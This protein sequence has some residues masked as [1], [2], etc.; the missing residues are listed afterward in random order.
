M[1]VI[2]MGNV[3]DRT[4]RN[5]ALCVS[6]HETYRQDCNAILEYVIQQG[7]S[8]VYT[9]ELNYTRELM[10]PTQE[11]TQDLN[12]KC[13]LVNTTASTVQ[14]DSLYADVVSRNN[15]T[16]NG[17]VRDVFFC[18]CEESEKKDH[19]ESIWH[20]LMNKEELSDQ[21]YSL[22][23]SVMT[24]LLQ[25]HEIPSC[26]V[27]IQ[28]GSNDEMNNIINAYQGFLRYTVLHMPCVN[29]LDNISWKIGYYLCGGR[30]QNYKY[31]SADILTDC[32]V[33]HGNC[34][35]LH[36]DIYSTSSEMS[37]II[38]QALIN[39][40]E[41]SINPELY[42]EYLKMYD[43]SEMFMAVIY[44]LGLM[45]IIIVFLVPLYIQHTPAA[46]TH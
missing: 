41:S 9:Q 30:C 29:M 17:N 10:N 13:Q 15:L 18:A 7:G 38:T 44:G 1:H 26:K 42:K 12:D 34:M 14:I 11:D 5:I 32:T 3:P 37:N 6:K 46:L 39:E 36:R 21:E 40:L 27:A 20:D 23:R 24:I 28:R 22:L 31:L 35:A 45:C 16:L 19:S 33:V 4:L 43:R 2:D 8:T 25:K